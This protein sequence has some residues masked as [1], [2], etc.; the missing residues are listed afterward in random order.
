VPDLGRIIESIEAGFQNEQLTTHAIVTVLL[1]VTGLSVYQFLI[2]RFVSKRSFYSKSF[3]LSLAA[4]PFFIATIIM[5]LQS[6][7]IITLG[8]IGALAII[9]F[10]TAIKDPMDMLYLLWSVH[11]GIVCGAGQYELGILTSLAVTILML[12]LDLIPMRKSPYLLTVQADGLQAEAEI[13]KTV[14]K[15]ARSH[16][17]KSRNMSEG[18]LDMIVELRTSGESCLLQELSAVAGVQRL[19]LLSHD[20]ES[21]L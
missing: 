19:S 12:V 20:G 15:Y 11:T 8:T 5:T 10:R 16:R 4:L 18:G 7:L 13:I 2:Y 17:V 6:N 21:I 9:R 14:R 1:M 3:N